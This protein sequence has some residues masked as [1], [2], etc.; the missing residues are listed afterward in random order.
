MR[1]GFSFGRFG[2]PAYFRSYSQAGE[3]AII[4]F[5]LK[6]LKISKPCYLDV[7]AYDP[8]TFSNTFAFYRTGAS[9]ICL[10]A[11]PVMSARLRR[12]RPRDLVLN[13]ALSESAGKKRFY[14]MRPATLS[15]MDE[16]EAHRLETLPGHSLKA[17]VSVESI[18]PA[19]LIARIPR[20]LDVL[21]FD[22]E[23]DGT[24]LITPLLHSAVRPA[25]VCCEIIGYSTSLM[26]APRH[27]DLIAAV[28]N[29]GYTMFASTRI[30]GIFIHNDML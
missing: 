29:A 6:T 4:S 25:V 15:T 20:K 11:N 27:D 18:T 22:I 21:S 2:R 3:D 1:L 10:E 13:A 19:D 12:R 9:G 14:V 26:G 24:A 16:T 17:V 5:L 8:V 28:E 7:G 23:G 30:N